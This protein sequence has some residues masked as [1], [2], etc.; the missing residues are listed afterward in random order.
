MCLMT[1]RA[2]EQRARMDPAHYSLHGG[3]GVR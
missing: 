3:K 2:T 1:S